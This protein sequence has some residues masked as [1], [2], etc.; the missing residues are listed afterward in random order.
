MRTY[1]DVDRRVLP[2]VSK[3]LDGMNK[4]AESIDPKMV[5][6]PRPRL[7]QFIDDMAPV[8]MQLHHLVPSTHFTKSNNTLMLHT[9]MTL[10]LGLEFRSQGRG[11]D[12]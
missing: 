4:A 7:H 1:A 5:R 11:M 3:C 10:G 9:Y 12:T 2:I 6:D 8:S